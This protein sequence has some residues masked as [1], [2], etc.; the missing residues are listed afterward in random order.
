LTSNPVNARDPA[1]I[2]SPTL[3]PVAMPLACPF[4]EATL[5]TVTAAEEIPRSAGTAEV[6]GVVLTS[7]GIAAPGLLGVP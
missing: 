5:V 7:T 1:G 3:V 2:G 6:P 4:L